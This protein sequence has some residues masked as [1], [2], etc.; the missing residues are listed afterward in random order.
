MLLSILGVVL[1]ER[2]VLLAILK[3]VGECRVLFSWKAGYTRIIPQVEPDLAPRFSITE[4][5][6]SCASG[7]EKDA[8]GFLVR[9]TLC[10]TLVNTRKMFHP[11]QLSG[12][13]RERESAFYSWTVS[14]PVKNHQRCV[15]IP[16]RVLG[17]GRRLALQESFL[18]LLALS[19]SNGTEQV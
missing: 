7:F 6:L 2:L 13:A 11:S 15:R 5:L 17:V 14:I 12:F 3:F 19:A 16:S 4:K 9:W 8:N 1:G 10:F 18:K